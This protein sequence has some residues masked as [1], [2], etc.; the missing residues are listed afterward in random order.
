[1][2]EFALILDNNLLESFLNHF[3]GKEIVTRAGRKVTLESQ[4]RAS[5]TFKVF[6]KLNK[7]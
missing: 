5:T 1:M 3:V 2:E 4:P 6:L 7:N